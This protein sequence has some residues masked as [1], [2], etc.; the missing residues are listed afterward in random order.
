MRLVVDANIVLAGLL[1]DGTTRSL[2]LNSS[3]HLYAPEHL[4]IETEKHLVV[5][6]R[7]RKRLKLPKKELAVILTALTSGIG[8]MPTRE[9][10]AYLPHARKIAP[11]AE[12]A[13]YLALALHLLTPLWSNDAGMKKQHEVSVITTTELL[14]YL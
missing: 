4:L 11:H 7:F 14:K 12:D 9:Y 5:S 8:V 13:P 6:D 1:R 3:L 2:L 10:R